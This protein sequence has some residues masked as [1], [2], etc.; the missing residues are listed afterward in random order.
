MD[1][2]VFFQEQTKHTWWKK[3]CKYLKRTKSLATIK[4]WCDTKEKES[5]KTKNK[6]HM[7]KDFKSD[8]DNQTKSLSKH[9]DDKDLRQ[10]KT[11]D[12][13]VEEKN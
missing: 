6:G 5:T 7:A 1:A 11:E 8:K 2:K 3:E 10:N 12:R 4:G 13:D 9:Y